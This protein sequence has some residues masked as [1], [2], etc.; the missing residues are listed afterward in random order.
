MLPPACASLCDSGPVGV[1][2]EIANLA[3]SE[4]NKELRDAEAGD[5]CSASGS[6]VEA[7]EEA[8]YYRETAEK[9]RDQHDRRHASHE[10]SGGCWWPDK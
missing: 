5:G 1:A 10:Q 9:D 4:H 6:V 7:D 2:Y 8:T 3:T